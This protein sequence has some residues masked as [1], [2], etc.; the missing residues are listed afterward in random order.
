MGV[1]PTLCFVFCGVSR[2]SVL[3]LLQGNRVAGHL[4]AEVLKCAQQVCYWP[5]M[6]RDIHQRST[7]VAKCLFEN[8]IR[9]HGIPEILHTDQGR[10]FESDL[11]SHLCKLLGVKKNCT[12]SYHPQCDGMVERFNRT[13][14]DQV[15]KSLLQQPDFNR[16]KNDGDLGE[17]NG[18]PKCSIS[19]Q[20]PWSFTMEK[21][22]IES[23]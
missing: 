21:A 11:I 16:L 10:Q 15:A 18:V 2:D 8:Y 23:H 7:T 17:H 5:F 1:L 9:E 19:Q 4:S 20:D 22:L 14:I 13:L 6:S 12:N 3:K